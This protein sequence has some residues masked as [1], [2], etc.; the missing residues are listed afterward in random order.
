MAADEEFSESSEEDLQ[1]GADN[2]HSDEDLDDLTEEEDEIAPWEE[3]F[4]RGATDDGQ[5]AKCSNCGK[6][7][8][9]KQTI[10]KEYDEEMKWFCSEKCIEEYEKHHA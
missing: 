5:A 9:R 4:I 10:E 3:G 2:A 7:V 6:A 1:D 8:V